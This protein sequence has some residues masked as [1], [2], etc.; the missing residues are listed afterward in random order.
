[1]KERLRSARLVLLL[2]APLL[3]LG[4]VAPAAMATAAGPTDL[5]ITT[6]AGQPEPGWVD[7]AGSAAR[8]DYPH[9]IA[10]DTAGNLYVADTR[11]HTIRKVTPAGVVTTIAGS[12]DHTAWADGSGSS[13]W[14][15][16]PQGIA[17]DE[18]GNIYV[19]DTGNN[20]IRKVTSEGTVSTLAGAPGQPGYVD[21]T[22]SDAL[23]RYPSGVACDPAGNV[24][25]ADYGNCVI[26]K[27]TQD[28]EVTTIAGV[29]GLSGHS[30]D[31]DR[32]TA[33][34]AGPDAVA[35][36]PDGNLYITET[37][38]LAGY[39]TSISS[40]TVRR[41][42]LAGDVTTLAGGPC[43]Y[44]GVLY[45]PDGV[46]CGP[47]GS[48]YVADTYNSRI[49]KVTPEGLV[50]TLAG[51]SDPA[52]YWGFLMRGWTDGIGSAA[53][54]SEP[55]GITADPDGN[56]YVADTSNNTIR[57]ITPEGS[58]STLAGASTLRGIGD[59]TGIFAHFVTPR[60]VAY[61]DGAVYV[62]DEGGAI[63][64][65]T[66]DGTVTT[67]VDNSGDRVT[68][69]DPYGL[70]FDAA[71]NLYVS[72]YHDS[73][74]SR[75]TPSGVVTT[76]AGKADE[77][78]WEEPEDYL[79]DGSGDAARFYCPEG[80]TCDAAGNVYVAD[81]QN[82][83]VR[84]V[85]PEGAVTTVGRFDYPTALAFDA[86]GGLY[87]AEGYRHGIKRLAPD[88]T[89]STVT[90]MNATALTCDDAGVLY[91]AGE[92]C[93]IFSVAPDGSV[94]A[95][96]GVAGQMGRADGVGSAARF[97]MYVR[98]L[99][100]DD[101]G[102]LYIS[103]SGNCL[104]RKGVPVPPPDTTP[105]DTSASIS[106]PEGDN[107]W[108]RGAVNIT[109]SADDGTGSGM[110]SG[111]AMIQWKEGAGD[112][113]TV[114]SVMFA[115][116]KSTVTFP[117]TG[118]GVWTIAYR[119]VDAAGNVAATKT[120]EVKIDGTAPSLTVTNPLGGQ[121]FVQGQPVALEWTASDALSG[122]ASVSPAK[123]SAIDTSGSGPNSVTVTGTDKAGNTTSKTVDYTLAITSTGVS[124]PINSDGSSV[125][126][127]RSTIPI[128]IKLTNALGLPLTG[129]NA[130]NYPTLSWT[131]IDAGVEGTY[132]EAISTNTPDK[133]S[134]LRESPT[135]PGL[136]I[137][138]L[139]ARQLGTGTFSLRIDLGNGAFLYGKFSIQ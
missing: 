62:A 126:S 80:L 28:G 97:A 51:Y 121:S 87:V 56:L 83:A 14:F 93:T 13:A 70:A 2:I 131:K 31:G 24:Y 95:L 123:G 84:K 118:D 134:M 11:S 75:I 4:S 66:P 8:F 137:F 16:Y 33:R 63:R 68:F 49:A 127:K 92:N 12:P 110:T 104:L 76:L 42:T 109:L 6:L 61:R 64:K 139:D 43:E 98:G 73:T 88:G 9:G 39:G 108:Y 69:S 41:V 48:V 112:I 44:G 119:A 74:I 10:R 78:N 65:M 138:N 18:A 125:F 32:T 120:I 106:G 77:I 30:V 3:I 25:V 50:T 71:G 72:D 15:N 37:G 102:T 1:M 107:G 91:A 19:A 40:Y 113:W 5:I 115:P 136:Y 124:Q 45:H 22:G 117:F 38:G 111:Q 81:S 79:I 94:T 100:W 58:V 103:D 122:L 59:G 135:T 17:C 96:A 132:L 60:Q 133:G 26:R 34:L 105:P 23:F 35:Y 128:K 101:S 57:T 85:T 82:N 54:F 86:A 20:V 29:G 47:D 7:G 89:I 55:S 46:A 52:V 21:A 130:N 53:G 114:S 99:A 67:L 90:S 129:L 27:V 116:H 36:G